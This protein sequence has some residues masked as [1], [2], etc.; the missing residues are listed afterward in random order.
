MKK[1]KQGFTLIELLAVIFIIGIISLIAI[2]AINKVTKQS[3]EELYQMQLKNIQS[4]AKNWGA[5]NI[6]ILPEVDGEVITLT[7]GQLKMGD[8][9]DMDIK[10]PRTR[11]LFPNDMEITITRVRN[12]YEYKVI[13]GT[14]SDVGELDLNS[15]SI[16]LNGLA[17]ETIEIHTEYIDKGVIARDPSGAA[18]DEIDITIRSNNNIVETIDTSILRQYKITYSVNHNGI[19]ASSIRTIT[20]KDTIPPILTIAGNIELPTEKVSTFDFMEGV[21]S[22]DNS[23]KEPTITTSGSI[24]TLPGNYYLN[25]TATD[26][27]GNKTSKIRRVTVI[28]CVGVFVDARDGEPYKTAQFG[29]QCWFAENLKYTGNGCLSKTWSSS[30]TGPV[31]A[32]EKNDDEIY[33]QWKAAMNGETRGEDEK[34]KVIQGLC[35]TGWHIPT[36]GEW[37]DLTDYVDSPAGTTLKDGPFNAKLAGYRN[38]SGAFLSVGSYGYWWTS[39][40]DGSDAW[41]HYMFSSN[42]N[43]YRGT[44]SQAYGHSVRCVRD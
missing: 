37:T 36:D 9:I 5:S 21:N 15:P 30:S 29:D 33:Y 8:F 42:S 39:S 32:C 20:V 27:S 13:E 19:T 7:L 17:H 24:S 16:T 12:N 6:A 38:P 40:P 14:G 4:G 43:V 34:D 1:A 22:S 41:F 28:A 18:I 23:L 10:D 26:E 25:Y 2:P 3:R 44:V 31:D 35:P 11:K